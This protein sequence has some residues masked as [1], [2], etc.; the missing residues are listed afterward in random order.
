MVDFC[1]LC[2]SIT[3]S[4][5]ILLDISQSTLLCNDNNA[6]VKWS[7]NMT[8]KAARHIELWKNSVQEWVQDK[9]INVQQVSGQFNPTDI[10]TKELQD[11]VHFCYLWDSFMSR[12]SDLLNLSLLAIYH[13]HQ[14][15]PNQV[16]PAAAKAIL[17]V[18]PSS[19]L[20][21]LASSSFCHTFTAISH[22]CSTGHQLLPN[23]HG[24]VP[25]HLMELF[26]FFPSFFLGNLPTFLGLVFSVGRTMGCRSVHDPRGV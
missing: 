5:H 9:T 18:H 11:G 8:S 14:R 3:N 10:F 26:C 16:L 23:L 13:T 1:N 15:P 21:A 7:Y 19:Y 25:S 17:M 12:L 4:G 6:W 22:H 2:W 20:S 24:I